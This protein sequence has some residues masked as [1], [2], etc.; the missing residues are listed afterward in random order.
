[1]SIRDLPLEVVSASAAEGQV[2]GVWQLKVRIPENQARLALLT[3]KVDGVLAHPLFEE[4]L[5]W[6]TAP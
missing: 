6:V 3:V 2:A 4:L 1:M 5:V